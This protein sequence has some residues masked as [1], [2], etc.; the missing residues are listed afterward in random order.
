M[1]GSAIFLKKEEPNIHAQNQQQFY[2]P[3]Q[4]SDLRK[5]KQLQ[6]VQNPKEES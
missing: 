1:Q 4:E 2:H 3:C 5:Q 6:E